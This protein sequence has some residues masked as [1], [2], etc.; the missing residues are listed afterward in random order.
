MRPLFDMSMVF[1]VDLT[2]ISCRPWSAVRPGKARPHSRL[3]EPLK[4]R[5]VLSLLSSFRRKSNLHLMLLSQGDAIEAYV[6]KPLLPTFR[7]VIAVPTQREFQHQWCHNQLKKTGSGYSDP[8][9]ATMPL[10]YFESP[11]RLFLRKVDAKG[12]NCFWKL[13]TRPTAIAYG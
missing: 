2:T 11:A 6:L 13:D 4:L 8:A 12:P 10:E 3:V 5:P 7:K 9:L 1:V